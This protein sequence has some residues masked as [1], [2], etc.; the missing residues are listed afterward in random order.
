M[1]N[2]FNESQRRRF[3]AY[4][5]KNEATCTMVCEALGIKQKTATWIKRALEK[6]GLLIETKKMSCKSTKRPAYYLTCN[7]EIIRNGIA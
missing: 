5:I 6:R 1:S 4:L 3:R 7:P 2:K